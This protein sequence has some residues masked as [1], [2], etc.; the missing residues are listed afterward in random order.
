V[1][2]HPGPG[3]ELLTLDA[4]RLSLSAAEDACRVLDRRLDAAR[5]LSRGGVQMGDRR[6]RT[7]RGTDRGPDEET[8]LAA[9]RR[10]TLHRPADRSPAPFWTLL[11]HLGLRPRTAAA[12]GLRERLQALERGGWLSR[13]TI[14]GVPVWSLTSKG[15]RRLG[16]ALRSTHPPQLPESP[17]HLAWRQARIAAEQEIGRFHDALALTLERA[18]EMLA[19]AELQEGRG[20]SSDDWLA[21]G[22]KLQGDCR[23]LGSAWH[24]LH[25][26]REPDDASADLD[27]GLGRTAGKSASSG[28]AR[29]RALR[30]GR[31]NIRLWDEPD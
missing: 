29:L 9:V 8:V 16:A 15:R 5:R 17:Q 14:R 7:Q 10:G 25:E 13:E 26:W 1:R 6:Q 21:L 22:R 23:R 18:R 12:R 31:R 19:E 28:S 11:E 27:R 24:C 20:P 3:T 2:E 30:A 4:R